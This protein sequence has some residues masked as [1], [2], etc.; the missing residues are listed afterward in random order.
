MSNNIMCFSQ[1]GFQ[2]STSHY[3]HGRQNSPPYQYQ[4]EDP[5]KSRRLSRIGSKGKR[6]G[7]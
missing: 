6:I 4:F 7:T 3:V 1:V 2:I 5:S